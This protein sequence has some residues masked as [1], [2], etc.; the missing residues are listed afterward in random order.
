M[1]KDTL[2]T[3]DIDSAERLVAFL[4]TSGLPVRAGVWFYESDAE[5]WRFI[6][7]LRERRDDVWSFY[8]NIA[9]AIKAS[10]RDDLLDLDRVKIVDQDDPVLTALRP[11][12]AVDLPSRRRISHSRINGVY[13]ENAMVLR[14]AA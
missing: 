10:G 8:F 9:D 11:D 13:F 14:L 1:A 3:E 12:Y 6:L 4:D 5:R 2:V 7:A